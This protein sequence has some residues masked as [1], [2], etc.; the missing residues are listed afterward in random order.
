[1]VSVI[2]DNKRLPDQGHLGAVLLDGASHLL[3]G[4]AGKGDILR[5][6]L[7]DG[8]TEVVV[9][10]VGG[11][12]GLAWDYNGRLFVTESR[13]GNLF[14][15]PRP[16]ADRVLVAAALGQPTGACL[17]PGGRSLLVADAQEGKLLA[18]PL[19]VPGAAVDERPL[20]LEPAVAFPDLK[21]TGWQ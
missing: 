13:G 8:S 21:W 10:G 16:G 2:L 6:K 11:V 3:V 18:F 14:V 12:S 19:A 20:A 15:V 4:D 17:A 7:A 5:V 1:Q 9:R